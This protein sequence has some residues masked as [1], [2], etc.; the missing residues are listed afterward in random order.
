LSI[1]RTSCLELKKALA[2]LFYRDCR[3]Q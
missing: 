3:R 2:A 1:D